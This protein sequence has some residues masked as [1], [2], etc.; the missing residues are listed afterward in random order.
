[1]QVSTRIAEATGAL[2]RAAYVAYVGSLLSQCWGEDIP[3]SGTRAEKGECCLISYD[4]SVS[5]DGGIDSILTGRAL[6]L[7]WTSF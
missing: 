4:I 7:G 1:M 5:H 3:Y 2:S 6:M